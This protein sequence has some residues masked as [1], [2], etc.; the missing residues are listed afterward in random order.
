MEQ[1]AAH[2]PA[3]GEPLPDVYDQIDTAALHMVQTYDAYRRYM[4]I[5]GEDFQLAGSLWF[6]HGALFGEKEFQVVNQY[7]WE[8]PSGPYWPLP[9]WYVHNFYAETYAKATSDSRRMK[10]LA[11]R[12][13]IATYGPGA[14]IAPYVGLGGPPQY[15]VVYPIK[16]YEPTSK[17]LVK[18]GIRIIRTDTLGNI[19]SVINLTGSPYDSVIEV[20]LAS[21]YNELDLVFT[22]KPLSSAANKLYYTRI[23]GNNVMISSLWS[24]PDSSAFFPEI[25]LFA[26]DSAFVSFA[27]KDAKSV[28]WPPV[29]DAI[30]TMEF[31]RSN[32]ASAFKSCYNTTVFWVSSDISTDKRLHLAWE[33]S[34]GVIKYRSWKRGTWGMPY[35][36]ASSNASHPDIAMSSSVANEAW[37]CW[38]DTQKD[39]VMVRG[40]VY[41]FPPPPAKFLGSVGEA[42]SADQEVEDPVPKIKLHGSKFYVTW[43]NN[44]IVYGPDKVTPNPY[45]HWSYQ[46]MLA[47]GELQPGGGTTYRVSSGI[48]KQD[49]LNCRYPDFLVKDSLKLMTIYTHGQYGI[50]R[51]DCQLQDLSPGV[52]ITEPQEYWAYQKD[53]DTIKVCWDFY[54]G[55]YGAGQK[56]VTI[57]LLDGNSQVIETK[58]VSDGQTFYTWFAPRNN[59][60][61]LY[62]IEV[63]VTDS[64]G[65]KASDLVSPIQTWYAVG[66]TSSN[67]EKVTR[68]S[69][70]DDPFFAY[71]GKYS[72]SWLDSLNSS[73]QAVCMKGAGDTA[74]RE[75][76]VLSS[77]TG[78][79]LIY[80]YPH[81]NSRRIRYWFWSEA[82]V[83]DTAITL[84]M[85]VNFTV[86]QFSPWV[87]G[88]TVHF[89][90]EIAHKPDIGDMDSFRFVYGKFCWNVPPG[91]NQPIGLV[92]PVRAYST[93]WRRPNTFIY[94][95]ITVSGSENGNT[96]CVAYI[97]HDTLYCIQWQANNFGVRDTVL[98]VGN[99]KSFDLYLHHGVHDT[100]QVIYHKEV[101]FYASDI[102][103]IEW[104]VDFPDQKTTITL[105]KGGEISWYGFPC[106]KGNRAAWVR[107]GASETTPAKAV[108]VA[109]RNQGSWSITDTLDPDVFT[110]L[111][112][113]HFTADGSWIV[114]TRDPGN[115]YGKIM[116]AQPSFGPASFPLKPVFALYAPYPSPA[117]SKMTVQFSIPGPEEYALR[118]Y[119]VAGRRVATLAEGKGEDGLHTLTWF[120]TNETGSRLPAG[121]YFMRLTYGESKKDVKKVVWMK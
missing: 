113:P 63:K 12:D 13:E 17:A 115:G 114:W 80:L 117:K 15:W 92:D 102:V 27:T 106:V 41:G 70:S 44:M 60:Y 111:A 25:H 51:V 108:F 56:S 55:S 100:V 29:G 6:S 74:S 120:G 76:T 68:L 11:S 32:P 38:L 34:N 89:V 37:I 86:L 23:I 101:T 119:D 78:D 116:W 105:Q 19:D 85:P 48:M 88:D 72:F 20:A 39:S 4:E 52:K 53:Q 18:K 46:I 9:A 7:P 87:V 43:E 81:T 112:W 97:Y 104:Q 84:D 24:K 21:T 58:S 22:S 79:T 61:D 42:K 26:S 83:M 30:R 75:P 109:T 54:R 71:W 36:V 1:G 16:E 82:G 94:P 2:S 45:K 77:G 59:I 99:I 35:I 28:P 49:P 14:K 65:K 67:T 10:L 57:N 31:Q 40:Q 47:M 73:N 98:K 64:M 90:A 62:K 107:T 33:E 103:L 110:G 118:I 91:S 121:V 66:N 95:D 5:Y 8:N 69:F 3:P 93:D 96:I 50:H